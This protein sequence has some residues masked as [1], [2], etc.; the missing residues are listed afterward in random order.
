MPLWFTTEPDDGLHISKTCS[1]VF[2]IK[3]ILLAID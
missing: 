1:W 2:L 3:C